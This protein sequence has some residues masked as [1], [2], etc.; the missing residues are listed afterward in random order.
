MHRPRRRTTGSTALIG[1]TL[2]ALGAGLLAAAPA[3]AA[4]PAATAAKPAAGEAP[5]APGAMSHFD[6]A[7]KDCVGTARNRSSKVWFT[8]AD[9]VLSD[10]YYPTIDTTNVET[11]QYVVT[12]G[13]SFTDLQTRD[14]TY[15]V[16]ALDSTGM[17]CRVTST[18]KSGRYSIVTDYLTDPARASVVMRSTL[19][20]GKGR[21]DLKVYVRFDGTINGNGGGG[22]DSQNG[23]ADTAVLDTSTK[24]PVPVSIDTK[25]ATIAANRDY[26]QPVYA[27]LRADRPFK[28]A[29]SGFAGTPSDGLAQLDA[30]HDLGTTY[31]TATNGNVVQTA[32]VDSRPG[33]PFQLAL[34]FGS[35]QSG[36]VATAGGSANAEFSSLYR[37]Y[38]RGWKRY[39]DG[40][41]P[42]GVSARPDP[43]AA[44]RPAPHLL[45]VGERAQGQRGQDVPGRHG[46]RR[47]PAPGGRPSRPATRP[48]PTSAPTARSSPATCTRPSPGCVAAGDLAT[49]K[50]TVRF[51]F[52]R[53]QQPD[54]SMPRNSLVNGKTGA[55]HVRRAARRGGLPDPDGPHRR[56]R[57]TRRSTPTTSSGPPTTSSRTAPLRQ[58]ALGGA[59]RLLALDDRRRDRRP[60]RGRLDRRAERRRRRGPHL[61]R[62]RRR[63]PAEHQEVDGHDER[64]AQPAA[65]LHPPLEERRPERA[66]S[67]TTS[68][69]AARRRPARGHRPGLPRAAPPRR[70]AGRRRRRRRARSPWST[71]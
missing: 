68:A 71:R 14:T 1:L 66:R 53:Q 36:A 27:A 4:V 12:D 51:L 25:T 38:R 35:T 48:T 34:G 17:S 62:H 37:D 41:T 29:S 54:G 40:L 7:R 58:R 46:R 57:P 31:A 6:L 42:A 65:V 55:R 28:R 50:D 18:A 10:V 60:R 61:P 67:A 32:L 52:E 21:Q 43:G 22:G 16:Q 59:E 39:D 5:G 23:G 9:G 44:P 30:T 33:K 8:I 3:N 19:L 24:H 15:T 47:W 69:T 49:A 63:L 70:A 11:L 20:P 26:A 13:K 45:P 56:A 2:G 64:P